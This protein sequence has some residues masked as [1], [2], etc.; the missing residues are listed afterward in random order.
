MTSLPAPPFEGSC[1]CLAQQTSQESEQH[2]LLELD[3]L[4]SLRAVLWAGTEPVDQCG[5]DEGLWWQ[6]W[7]PSVSVEGSMDVSLEQLG[8]LA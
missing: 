5:L 6:V 1:S 7:G 4:S 3:L 8:S 2:F